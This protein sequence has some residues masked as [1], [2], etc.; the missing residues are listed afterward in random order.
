MRSLRIVAAALL[1]LA[2]SAEAREL[3]LS[4]CGTGQIVAAREFDPLASQDVLG[5]AH[6]EAGLGLGEL[7]PGLSLELAWEG[8][9]TTSDLFA[10]TTPWLESQLTIHGAVLTAAWRLPLFAWL[11]AT[12]RAG[13]TLDFAR[14]RFEKDG[15]TYLSDWANARMGV[16]AALGAELFLPRNTWRRW[17]GLS[18]LENNEGFTLGLRLEAGWSY[19]QGFAFDD[20]TPP[21]SGSNG[22]DIKSAPIDLGSLNLDGFFFRLGLVAFF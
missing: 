20:M 8:G 1:W 6:V 10:G 4:V 15:R 13:M 5:L 18:D 7:L 22:S 21:A 2:G 14:L 16:T 17:F 11:Q 9:T 19:R 3:T 12:A